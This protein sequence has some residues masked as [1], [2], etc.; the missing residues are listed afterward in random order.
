[1]TRVLLTAA[2]LLS[3]IALSAQPIIIGTDPSVPSYAHSPLYAPKG[4]LQ[5][6]KAE[7]SYL[8]KLSIWITPGTTGADNYAS[9]LTITFYK[10]IG[11]SYPN[12]TLYHHKPDPFFSGRYDLT[13]VNGLSLQ[14]GE[15]YS[16]YFT[17][18]VCNSVGCGGPIA[19]WSEKPT[20]EM[21]VADAYEGEAY[22]RSMPSPFDNRFPGDVRFEMVQS[23]QVPA[24]G[25]ASLLLLG[26]AVFA[27]HRWRSTQG[28]RRRPAT[29]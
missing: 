5:T 3:P 14:V 21:T 8:N 18:G 27:M 4:V 22:D 13:F 19:Q 6:F 7:A 12:N 17:A 1:M 24:P 25:T 9:P 2:L 11:Q 23:N 15:W 16:M 26:M 10:G 29:S 28:R 20:I